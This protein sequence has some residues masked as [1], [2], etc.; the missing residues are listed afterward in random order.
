MGAL[1]LIVASSAWLFVEWRAA[2]GTIADSSYEP[3]IHTPLFSNPRPV[4]L[5]DEAHR[6][7]HALNGSYKPFRKLATVTGMV[8]QPLREAPTARNLHGAAALMVV[9]ALGPTD[10]GDQP[11]F[12]SGDVSVIRDFVADGG[13]LILVVD[14]YPFADAAPKLANAFGVELSRGMTVDEEHADKTANDG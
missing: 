14:H 10:P 5:F 11:A 7:R 1:L 2:H 13:G 3:A 6:N 12:S 9:L 4:M 8:V